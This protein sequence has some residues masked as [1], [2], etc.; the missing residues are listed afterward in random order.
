MIQDKNGK[1]T[2]KPSP[3]QVSAVNCSN[4]PLKETASPSYITPLPPISL[5]KGGGAIKGIGEKFDVNPVTGTASFSIP[6]FTTPSRPD[7]FLKLSLSF[8]SGVESW[9]RLASSARTY[10]HPVP[11]GLRFAR[12]ARILAAQG[13]R[14][15]CRERSFLRRTMGAKFGAK[16]AS[17]FVW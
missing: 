11:T 6:I 15:C 16:L 8:D 4:C 3:P 7:F 13:E 12:C 5:P 2:G 10:L 14:L 1:N 17:P 9:S